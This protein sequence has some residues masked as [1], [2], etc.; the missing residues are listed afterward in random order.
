[1]RLTRKIAAFA[2][3]TA[4]LAGSVLA[5]AP[6]ATATE[7]PMTGGAQ[8]VAALE[9]G[10]GDGSNGNPYDFQILTTALKATGLDETLKTLN[11]ITVFAPNDRAFEVL[12]NKKGLLG[13]GYRYGATVDEDKIVAALLKLPNPVETISAIVLYHVYAKGVLP[14]AAVVKLPVF[15]TKLTM[16]NQQTLGVTNLTRFTGGRPTVI[17]GDKDG[18]W[19][20]DQVVRSKV[21]YV[22][23]PGAVVHGISDVL[24]PK[25]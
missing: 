5:T 20:N 12:A 13:K 21:D 7:P 14:G 17:L 15:G 16:V 18:N 8:V 24:L 10:Y 1:M 19:F 4:L 11:N 23:V 6:A 25:L 2:A 3:G 9:F 22:L